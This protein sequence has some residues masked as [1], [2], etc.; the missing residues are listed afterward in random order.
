MALLAVLFVILTSAEAQ[1]K[2]RE[3]VDRAR[4]TVSEAVDSVRVKVDEV[5]EPT[6]E[7]M[8]Y[9]SSV[10][11]DESMTARLS[12]LSRYF[13]DGSY[14]TV[15]ASPCIH[16]GGG[17]VCPD[18]TCAYGAVVQALEHEVWWERACGGEWDCQKPDAT[19][20][21][22]FARFVYHAVRGTEL[23][24]NPEPDASYE[25]TDLA[26]VSDMMGR[27]RAGDLIRFCGE[28]EHWAVFLEDAGVNVYLY[29]ANLDGC[30]GV[31]YRHAEAL[32]SLVSR[33]S[34]YTAEIYR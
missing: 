12:Q 14:F 22:S 19:G 2:I 7:E 20:S 21:E 26:S 24:E 32:E 8:S 6:D 15:D 33:F 13:P 34:G 18:G 5:V 11:E 1:A 23:A 25:L 16:T 4:G 10:A 31:S 3:L 17:L 9:L 30:E 28:Q 27:L 29:E